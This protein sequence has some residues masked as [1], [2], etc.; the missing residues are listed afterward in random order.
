MTDVLCYPKKL[1]NTDSKI[2]I[3]NTGHFPNL[4]PYTEITES[5]YTPLA[6]GKDDG[7]DFKERIEELNEE[8]QRSTRENLSEEELTVF[9]LLIKPEMKLSKKE[10]AEVKKVAK[11]LLLTIK[12]N[13]LVLDWR[14]RQQSRAEVRV[15]IDEI[16]DNLPRA[17]TPEIYTQKCDIIYQH[18]FDSYSGEGTLIYQ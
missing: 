7:F 13:K 15:C 14:K 4:K 9:D 18:V 8:E 11:D 1:Y 2:L 12:Q 5:R 3:L 10:E 6:T 16:L 17:Y